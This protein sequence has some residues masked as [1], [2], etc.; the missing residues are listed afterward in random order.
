LAYLHGPLIGQKQRRADLISIPRY[1]AYFGIRLRKDHFDLVLLDELVKA[2]QV[3]RVGSGWKSIG[4][5]NPPVEFYARL[6]NI[7]SVEEDLLAVPADAQAPANI[8]TGAASRTGDQNTSHY[9]T[10]V[11]RFVLVW[12]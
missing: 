2:R 11:S 9:D 5:V 3:S 8:V 10:L 7:G 1:S 6:V 12:E 4:S